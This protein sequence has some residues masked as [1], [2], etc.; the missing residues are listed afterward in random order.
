[1][2]V[3]STNRMPVKHTR[4]LTRG[5]PPLGLESCLGSKGSTI[6]HNSSVTSGLDIT[7]SVNEATVNIQSTYQKKG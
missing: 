6:P 1:M 2:P 5:R 3:L 4:S 7:S